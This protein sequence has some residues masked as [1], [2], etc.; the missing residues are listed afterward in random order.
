MAC[1]SI[2]PIAQRSDFA[3]HIGP[4]LGLRVKLASI[5]RKR[6]YHEPVHFPSDWRKCD[7]ADARRRPRCPRPEWPDDPARCGFRRRRPIAPS[8]LAPPRVGGL[9]SEHADPIKGASQ[10]S[11][12]RRLLFLPFD[13]LAFWFFALIWIQGLFILFYLLFCVI[14]LHIFILFSILL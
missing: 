3:L 1:A 8:V 4:F 9:D 6:C 5:S 13:K 10:T 2:S 14:F 7:S 11:S 12:A